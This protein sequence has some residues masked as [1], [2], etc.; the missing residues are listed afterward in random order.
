MILIVHFSHFT[1]K[2]KQDKWV[3]VVAPVGDEGVTDKR[4]APGPA[5]VHSSVTVFATLLSPNTSLSHAFPESLISKSSK[6][7]IHVAQ[8]SGYNPGFATGA[9]VNV[10]GSDD[11]VAEL[12]EGDGAYVIAD[13]G[14]KLTVANAG[15]ST[16]EVLLFVVG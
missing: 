4:E 16:A 5:P 8:T 11:N 14:S 12:R 6:A 2:E 10:A 15:N 7:Y 3:R 1:D 9:R 13:S